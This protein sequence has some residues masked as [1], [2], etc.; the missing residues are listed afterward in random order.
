MLRPMDLHTTAEQ[1]SLRDAV[2]GL[3][4]WSTSRGPTAS[5]CRPA[6]TTWPRRSRSG[7][8]GRPTWPPTAGSASPGP[9]STAGRGLGALENYVVIEELARARAPELVG[10]IGINLVGPTLLAHGTPEQKERFLPRILSAD[11]LWCQLFSEPDAGSDLASLTTR[12]VPVDGGYRVSGRKV[13]TSYAQF[14]DW[15]LCLTRTD[16]DGAEA[17]AG[18]HRAHRRHARR[19]RRT[20]TRSCSR[21]ARPSSTRS[22]W[23]TSSCRPSGASATRAQGWTRRRLDPGPR[24]R[25][26]PPPARDPHPAHRGTAPPGRGQREL[27]RL[28]PAPAAGAGSHRG[29]ALPAAQLALADPPVQGRGARA[30]GQRP[31]AVLERDVQAAAP[32]RARR[33]RAGRRPSGRVRRGTPPTAP[34]S[35]R[36]CTTRRRPSSP[37]PTRSSGRS[38]ASASSGCRGADVPGRRTRRDR[39]GDSGRMGDMAE[40][41]ETIRYE[42]DGAV[43]TITMNRPE[44]ANAQNSDAHRRDRRRLRPGRRRRRGAGRDPGRR[45]ASTSPRATTSRPWSAATGPTRG[46]HCA[47]PPRASSTTRRRCTTTAACA[48]TTSASR[49]S[50]PSRA[51]ASPPA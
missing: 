47:R 49:R 45:R 19:G 8:A 12:A 18:H 30:R 48:S 41:F 20:C 11:E 3:A 2:P 17:P 22:S 39:M 23:T 51:A 4:A 26:Q 33:A 25:D 7:G 46:W 34:G 38:W 42:T 28:A 10:R 32:D 31:Q 1:E 37:A 24:A 13:W 35:A 44:V 50:P 40:S 15:G 9:R 21:P 43:A 36:G 27:R 6:S 14:A 29:P 16:P 5:G